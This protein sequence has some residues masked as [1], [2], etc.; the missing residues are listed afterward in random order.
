MKNTT[1]ENIEAEITKLQNQTAEKLASLME[2]KMSAE[3]MSDG[4]IIAEE[5][6]TRLCYHNH[7]DGCGWL[8][9][10]WDNISAEHRN[11]LA[12][13]NRLITACKGLDINPITFLKLL[14][15]VKD[16]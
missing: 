15:I 14:D 10:S 5:L 3:R 12:K 2:A 13:A 7:T 11:Y 9:A 4:M 6:H 1:A 8:Y 16:R